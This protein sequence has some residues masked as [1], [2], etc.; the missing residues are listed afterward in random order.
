MT[1]RHRAG[2]H[3]LFLAI[4]TFCLS[5]P[6]AQCANLPPNK[7]KNISFTT[8]SSNETATIFLNLLPNKIHSFALHNP[9]RIIIDLRNT[10]VPEV[11]RSCETGGSIIQKVRIGQNRK[12]ITRIVLEV[13]DA[14][15]TGYEIERV[16]DQ[17]DKPGVRIIAYNS[18][19]QTSVDPASEN[20]ILAQASGQNDQT[21][22]SPDASPL[23]FD[24]PLPDDLF[25]ESRQVEEQKD[26]T[27]T[28]H[29]RVRGSLDT[30]REDR[31]ENNTS[32]RKRLLLETR[33]KKMFTLS[34]LSDYLYFGPENETDDYDLD[35]YEATWKYSNDTINFV[36]GKQIIRWGKTDQISPV[37]TIN[38]RDLR[39][40]IIP[41]YEETK[42]P[43]WMADL[44]V[45]FDSFQLQAIFIPSFEE[46]DIDYFKTD[47]AVFPHIKE[48]L[49]DSP[50]PLALKRY[51]KQLSVHEE[52]PDQESEIGLRLST[53]IKRIDLDISWHHTR[54]DV[55]YFA[56]F[57]VKN[58]TVEGDFSEEDLLATINGARL[59]EENIEVEYRRTE[60][61]GFAF[62]TTVGDYG[63]R[64][65][66]AWHEN[67]TFLTSSLTSVRRPVFEYILGTDY[68]G[69]RDAYI[70]LQFLHR[71]I[72][73]HDPT[74]LYFDEDTYSLLGEI[75]RDLLSDWLE[76]GLHY[77]FT[78][79]DRSYYISPR[80]EFTYVTN[81]NLIIGLNIFSGEE[82]TWLGR[83][84]EDDQYFLEMTYS[85]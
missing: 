1:K 36:V 85:F 30:E 5:L 63:V 19:N 32:L 22:S 61:A 82:D 40:F 60:T 23:L 21:D 57:P 65:E 46:T 20:L 69:D 78:L 72:Y 56:S 14:K 43:V 71:H 68:T 9:E 42:I 12:N 64:G 37:D 80:F 76:A 83:F 18:R 53:T 4:I 31:I 6:E 11:N 35:L 29:I 73:D 51:F 81:L 15:L 55:P 26:L 66:A 38:P 79:N 34:V 8:G 13:N 47:W 84:A 25:E 48:E 54:E 7:I 10:F 58:I 75:S 49:Q 27:I 44:T 74:I 50:L 17:I 59:T 45:F 33:Y 67:Q 52:D 24:E 62:E 39:E 70:N 28:G 3:T 2:L 41:E 77:S 16:I